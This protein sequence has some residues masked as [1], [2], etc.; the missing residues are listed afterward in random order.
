MLDVLTTVRIKE[1]SVTLFGKIDTKE[2]T[3]ELKFPLTSGELAEVS[4]DIIYSPKMNIQLFDMM[5][6]SYS[7]YG[8]KF[9]Q[10]RV[11]F[12]STTVSV[13]KGKFDRLIQERR[14]NCTYNSVSLCFSG[15]EKLFPFE[16]FETNWNDQ[17]G[18]ITFSKKEQ[19]IETFSLHGNIECSVKSVLDGVFESN[20][21]YNLDIKQNK[22]M[23]LTFQ[24]PQSIDY[25]LSIV[26]KVKQFFE[27]MLKQEILITDIQFANTDFE[28]RSSKLV[29]DPI[30]HPKTIIKAVTDNPYNYTHETLFA[31]LDGWLENYDEYCDVIG[32]WQKTIY[33]TSVS[34]EDLFIW[35]CQAFELLCSINTQ[36]IEKANLLKKQQNPN[37]I[38]LIEAVN[39]IFKIFE[40][41][42][43]SFYKDLKNVR[44]K[45]IHNNPKK[46]VTQTQKENSYTLIEFFLIKTM[47]EI[48]SVK[49]ISVSLFLKCEK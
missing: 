31:G 16:P 21:L 6:H 23:V 45:L 36:I 33:N 42:D 2:S 47:C 9:F 39:S 24:E 29:C 25:L 8:C 4:R 20:T 11:T 49:G 41:L 38:N 10:S 17:T 5:A 44:D 22:A 1:T 35:R 40:N 48:F 19:T 30:L 27:F 14:I 34:L 7:M 18:E 15:I 43:E 13:I 37:L 3:I 12:A 32:L 28:H 46:V 26:T